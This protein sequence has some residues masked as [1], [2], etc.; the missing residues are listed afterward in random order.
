MALLSAYTPPKDSEELDKRKE[1]A[2]IL[3][4]FARAEVRVDPEQMV[5]SGAEM[6]VSR[7]QLSGLYKKYR[8]DFKANPPEDMGEL[9]TPTTIGGTPM[10]PP[11]PT[12][13]GDDAKKG[14]VF[15]QQEQASSAKSTSETAISTPR[16]DK[17][18]ALQAAPF[19]SSSTLNQRRSLESEGGKSMRMARMLTRKG[20]DKAAEQMALAGAQAKMGEP[21]IRTQAY[22]EQQ[23]ALESKTQAEEQKALEEQKRAL[24]SQ[25]RLIEARNK[26]AIKEMNSPEGL[27]SRIASLF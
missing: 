19:G 25:R 9:P 24:E 17:Y 13:L 1:L 15:N 5:K 16:L 18:D 26:T 2:S 23:S 7:G 4:Q 8:E 10:G 3:K 12:G 20:Y 6:G 11:K 14:S 27:S 22:R 21:S